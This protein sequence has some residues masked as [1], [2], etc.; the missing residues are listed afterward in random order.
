MLLLAA[1]AAAGGAWV[2]RGVEQAAQPSLVSGTWLP[3]P[4]D[5]GSFSLV[6]QHGAPFGEARLDGEPTLL[7]FGFTHCPDVCP[8]SLARL[9]QVSHAA[10]VPPVRVIF[11]TLDPARDTPA[12]LAR[13]VQAFDPRF[14]ALTGSAPAIA[15]L[16][17]RLGVAY[18]R[19]ELPGGDYTIDHSAAAFLLDDAGRIVAVFT[20]PFDAPQ[21]AEDLRRAAP[22]LRDLRAPDEIPLAS[23]SG[24]PHG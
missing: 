17:K 9:A 23:A 13:Y 16:A 11:V 20:A 1:C 6:D 3:R 10:G 8:T 18:E 22:Y 7:F 19:V 14:L 21:L 15:R 24:A 12:V 5:I 2:A 4:R